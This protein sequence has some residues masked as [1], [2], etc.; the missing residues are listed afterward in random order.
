MYQAKEWYVS[1]ERGSYALADL[2]SL[3]V[4]EHIVACRAV[5]RQRFG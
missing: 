5:C 3:G 4:H 1:L 2:N